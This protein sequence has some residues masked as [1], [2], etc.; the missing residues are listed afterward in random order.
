MMMTNWP[1]RTGRVA[2]RRRRWSDTTPSAGRSS[3]YP[4]Q[5]PEGKL[6]LCFCCINC[7]Y[8]SV[9]LGRLSLSMT[10]AVVITPLSEF[11]DSSR[12]LSDRNRN[13]MWR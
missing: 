9:W 1:G 7:N 11:I 6:L 8:V 3:N 13:R 4:C 2:K 5:W 10:S 12:W